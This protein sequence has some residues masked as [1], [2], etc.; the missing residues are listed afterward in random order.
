[1]ALADYI[2]LKTDALLAKAMAGW[3]HS[4]FTF[5]TADQQD[6]CVGTKCISRAKQLYLR[7]QVN[8]TWATAPTDTKALLSAHLYFK[9]S[10]GEVKKSTKS[11]TIN[12]NEF[13]LTVRRTKMQINIDKNGSSLITGDES[14]HINRNTAWGREKGIT[15]LV[16]ELASDVPTGTAEFTGPEL[17]AYLTG[18]EGYDQQWMTTVAG[19]LLP[20]VQN[21]LAAPAQLGIPVT[22]NGDATFQGR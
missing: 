6:G 5:P 14:I 13:H 18:C 12:L 16:R 8:A 17:L 20:A 15:N 21:H 7:R 3:T 11:F 22:A 4:G 19:L 10:C 2:G 9:V 1:M